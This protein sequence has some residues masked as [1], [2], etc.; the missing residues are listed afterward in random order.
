M[1]S[2]GPQ[3]GSLVSLLQSKL[4]RLSHM[5]TGVLK[6][7]QRELDSEAEIIDFMEHHLI[8][9]KKLNL[10]LHHKTYNRS[11]SGRGVVD[12]E[13]TSRLSNPDLRLSYGGLVRQSVLSAKHSQLNDRK[14]SKIGSVKEGSPEPKTVEGI[15]LKLDLNKLHKVH[16]SLA[17]PSGGVALVNTSHRTMHEIRRLS[18][19]E[20]KNSGNLRQDVNKLGMLTARGSLGG[21]ASR[22]NVVSDPRSA[23]RKSKRTDNI[24]ISQLGTKININLNTRNIF[25]A[26]AK[27]SSHLPTGLRVPRQTPASREQI[28]IHTSPRHITDAHQRDILEN[29]PDPKFYQEAYFGNLNELQA[30]TS[31]HKDSF[32]SPEKERDSFGIF[33]D[34]PSIRSM[35]FDKQDAP[36]PIAY[37][38][39]SI[40]LPT[41]ETPSLTQT[42]FSR[43]S[44]MAMDGRNI[45]RFVGGAQTARE[46]HVARVTDKQTKSGMLNFGKT[47]HSVIFSSAVEPDPGASFGTPANNKYSFAKRR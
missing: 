44:T 22:G 32:G 21:A 12:F 13:K 39:N 42:L 35:S 33:M 25:K 45:D 3:T 37:V 8:D 36:S 27:N 26:T 10:R 46:I 34:Q 4:T 23:E 38:R 30:I 16:E 19:Y 47:R 40:H 31:K 43:R 9:L 24:S 1:M 11:M 7:S 2:V 20:G 28:L 41:K 18:T 29:L 5:L 15:G 6:Q 17:T 14:A